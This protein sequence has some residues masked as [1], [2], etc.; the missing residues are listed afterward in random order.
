M[1]IKKCRVE[2]HKE[3]MRDSRSSAAKKK[4]KKVTED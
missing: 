3:S 2:S 1:A 4:I